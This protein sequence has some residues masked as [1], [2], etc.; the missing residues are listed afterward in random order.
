MIA[1]VGVLS[2]GGFVLGAVVRVVVAR[3][4][5]S[6]SAEFP[7]GGSAIIAL[8]WPRGPTVRRR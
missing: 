7:D 5:P 2:A 1:L 3:S 4:D 6:A 8:T